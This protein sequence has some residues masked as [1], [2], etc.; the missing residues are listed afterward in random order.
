MRRLRVLVIAVLITGCDDSLGGPPEQG[1]N[2]VWIQG[3]GFNPTPLTVSPGT[4]VAWTNKD[5]QQ[6][7]VTGSDPGATWG[8]EQLSRNETY[9]RVFSTIG[10]Y[11][12]S[13]SNH[14]AETGR[15][16]VK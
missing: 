9:E 3:S 13:C 14:P 6:H 4:R 10:S 7:T 1:P 5:P 2:D 16:V 8:S 15:I 12:Y 11:N